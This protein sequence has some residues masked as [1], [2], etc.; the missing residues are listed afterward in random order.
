MVHFA[1]SGLPE[2]RALAGQDA[3]SALSGRIHI[4]TEIDELERAF[5]AAKYGDFSPRPYCEATIP[6]LS[7]PSLAPAGSHVMSVRAQYAPYTLKSGTWADR[8]D[9]FAPGRRAGSSRSTRPDSRTADRRHAGAD[10]ARPRGDLRADGRPR[11]PRRALARPA[12]HDAAAARLGALPDADRGPLPVRLRHTSGRRIPGAS[13]ANASREIARDLRRLARQA[14]TIERPQGRRRET[15]SQRPP[16]LD[17]TS[18]RGIASPTTVIRTWEV[19][20]RFLR[21]TAL[22]GALAP[23]GRLVPSR[24]RRTATLGRNRQG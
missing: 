3:A 18:P 15:W 22:L 10:A 16:R 23:P 5:D 17:R 12:L 8:R 19:G 7:D 6:T 1:L 21:F 13:G 24:R 11:L 4:G 14:I 20:M 2:F 9:E